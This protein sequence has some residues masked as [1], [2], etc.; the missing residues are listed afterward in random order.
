MKKCVVLFSSSLLA[1]TLV[2]PALAD[3]YDKPRMGMEKM[4]GEKMGMMKGECRMDEKGMYGSCMMEGRHSMTGMVDKIDQTK[5]ALTLKYGS[6]EM[7]L[8]FPP[9]ALK[10]V[11]NGDTI[12]VHLGFTKENMPKKSGSY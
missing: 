1:A 4:G 10:E 3:S 8:H 11:K 9:A 5:G 7:L 2:F 6:S 12:T